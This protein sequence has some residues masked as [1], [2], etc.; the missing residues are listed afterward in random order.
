MATPMAV[1]KLHLGLCSRKEEDEIHWKGVSPQ[2]VTDS[3]Q[4]SNAPEE[5]NHNVI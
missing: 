3:G 2:R 4:T 5:I 1:L